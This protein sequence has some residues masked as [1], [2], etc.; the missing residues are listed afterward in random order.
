ML[1]FLD[2]IG[3]TMLPP[4]ITAMKTVAYSAFMPVQTQDRYKCKIG[5]GKKI[6]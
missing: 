2:I 3:C 6:D 5:K 4:T 1:F